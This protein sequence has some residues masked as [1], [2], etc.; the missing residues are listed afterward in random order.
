LPEGFAVGA[1]VP[2]WY[3]RSSPRPDLET[4]GIENGLRELFGMSQA[5]C[6]WMGKRGRSLAMEKFSWDLVGQQMKAVI[7]WVVEGGPKPACVIG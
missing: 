5:E 1:A 3:G 2:I 7:R 4:S 6:A